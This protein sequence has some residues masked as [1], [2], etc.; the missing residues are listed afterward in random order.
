MSWLSLIG[1]IVR[2]LALITQ[3]GREKQWIEQGEANEIMREMHNARQTIER[4]VVA[5][6]IA[7]RNVADTRRLRQHDAYER[8]KTP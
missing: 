8:D 2:L 7:G 3:K 5:R 6:R 1:A 4:M